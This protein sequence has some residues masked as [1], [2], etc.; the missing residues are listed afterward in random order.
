M[1][2]VNIYNCLQIFWM[3][4]K[5]KKKNPYLLHNDNTPLYF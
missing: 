4:I 3:K 1:A 2:I 5:K